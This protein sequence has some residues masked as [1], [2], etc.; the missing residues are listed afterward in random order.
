MTENT[1]LAIAG[2]NQW[3]YFCW[4]YKCELITYINHRGEEETEY[5][6]TFL[7]EVQW[8]CPL[9]HM[10]NK[11]FSATSGR[12]AYSYLPRF[13]AELDSQNSQSLLEWVMLN[14]HTSIF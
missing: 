5:L 3:M 2:I 8:T 9:A 13:Y 10:I 11:W 4:N 12:D 7:K 1:E 14:Y 6:P